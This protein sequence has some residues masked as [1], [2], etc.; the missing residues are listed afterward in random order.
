MCSSL[1]KMSQSS[2]A[3]SLMKTLQLANALLPLPRFLASYLPVSTTSVSSLL[4]AP[5]DLFLDI[6]YFGCLNS[7]VSTCYCE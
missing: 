1:T 7:G 5:L 3:L 6:E 2:F 4:P